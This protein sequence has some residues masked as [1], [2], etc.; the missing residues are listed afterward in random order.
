MK[1]KITGIFEEDYGCEGVPEDEELMCKVLLQ[2][3]DGNEKWV[4]LADNYLTEHNL[5]EGD[6]I[7]IP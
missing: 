5:N 6:I 2:D 1:Y 7:E 3:S 4:K